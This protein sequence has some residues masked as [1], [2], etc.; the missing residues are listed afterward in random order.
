MS[1]VTQECPACDGDL[2]LKWEQTGEAIACPHCSVAL[3]VEQ[4][5]VPIGED[6]NVP[7]LYAVRASERTGGEQT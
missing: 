1:D 7:I 2:L 4:D 3:I 6:G 5:S